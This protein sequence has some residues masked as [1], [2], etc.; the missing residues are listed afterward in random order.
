MYRI[1]INIAVQAR[2]VA[3]LAAQRPAS[4]SKSTCEPI[5]EESAVSLRSRRSPPIYRSTTRRFMFSAAFAADNSLRVSE[6]H[7]IDIR[8]AA[9]G[10]AANS[11]AAGK[12][13]KISS[14][15]SARLRERRARPSVCSI[16]SIRCDIAL[17]HVK[18]VSHLGRP[19]KFVNA[20]MRRPLSAQESDRSVFLAP[21]K[22]ALTAG[23]LEI[24][25]EPL[26]L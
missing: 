17:C 22:N 26:A 10:F 13:S 16:S 21:G 12:L 3:H 6:A 25:P 24:A 2:D 15:L 20:L 9:F 14:I 18:S 8:A 11:L 1:P 19:S 23:Q 7:A 5:F 4:G